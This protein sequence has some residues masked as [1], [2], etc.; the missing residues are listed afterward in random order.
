M[1]NRRFGSNAIM[2]AVIRISI[3]AWVVLCVIIVKFVM[4]YSASSGIAYIISELKGAGQMTDYIIYRLLVLIIIL[5]VSGI[6]FNMFRM[7][8][9]SDKIRL[10]PIVSTILAVAGIIYLHLM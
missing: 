2:N 6:L 10:F 5:S 8:R 7:K 1:K 9:R 4:R 3:L